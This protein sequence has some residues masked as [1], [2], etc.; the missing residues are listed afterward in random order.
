MTNLNSYYEQQAGT[1]IAIYPGAQ[2]QRGRGFFGRFFR[3]SLLPL[4]QSLGQKL[5]SVGVDVADDVVN[6][7][8]DP[9]TSL[10]KRGK[11]V[12]KEAA[13]DVIS[14]ARSKLDAMKKS[15][16][17]S[18][19]SIKGRSKTKSVS[20]KSAVTKKTSNSKTSTKKKP[21][22]TKKTVAKTKPRTERKT[23]ATK[24][25][26]NSNTKPGKSRALSFLDY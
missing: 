4:L 11:A 23:S 13:N 22:K 3:G 5:L 10:K 18:G 19:K 9:L 6:K 16:A 17:G 14:T 2:Y 7:D 8:V 24:A 26:P 15:Q 12:A 25:R 1:G 21:R 20:R